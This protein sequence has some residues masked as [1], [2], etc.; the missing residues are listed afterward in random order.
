MKYLAIAAAALM[1]FCGCHS[2]SNYVGRPGQDSYI[3]GA[4]DRHVDTR[5]ADNLR[6]V[7]RQGSP[8]SPFTSGNGSLNF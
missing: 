7:G 6:D 4:G 2:N 1:V 5:G 8:T 3:E